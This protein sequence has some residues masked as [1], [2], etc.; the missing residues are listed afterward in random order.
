[1]GMVMSMSMSMG[2]GMGMGK[3]MGKGANGP[4]FDRACD[5][6]TAAFALQIEQD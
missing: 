5:G 2:M 4:E 1:M 6:A 3:D